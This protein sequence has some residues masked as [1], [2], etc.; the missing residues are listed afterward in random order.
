MMS[1]RNTVKTRSYMSTQDLRILINHP[2]TPRLL[3][4]TIG[5]KTHLWNT[6]PIASRDHLWNA[7]SWIEETWFFLYV[8]FSNHFSAFPSSCYP[9]LLW[10][11]FFE[12]CFL[13][14]SFMKQRYQNVFL[15]QLSN[16][17]LVLEHAD[18]TVNFVSALYFP[19]IYAVN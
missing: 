12:S 2:P 16:T 4:L 17:E 7:I 18:G 13:C 9:I 1:Q 14:V 10:V 19:L 11:S 8:C 3:Y 5:C 15:V 6:V